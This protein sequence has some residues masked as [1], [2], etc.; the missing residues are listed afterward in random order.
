LE[1]G[2]RPVSDEYKLRIYIKIVQLFLEDEESVTAESYLNRAALI[3]NPSTSRIFS[4]QFKACQ[5]RIL[6]F[7]R[8][9]LKASP[10]YHELSYLPELQDTDQIDAL[11]SALICAVL[12]PACPQRSRLLA[13]LYKDERVRQRAEFQQGGLYQILEKMYLDRLL[14]KK[15]VEQFSENLKPHQLARHGDNTTVLDRAVTEHNLVAASKLYNNIYLNQL[16]AL[17]SI[18]EEQAELVAMKMISDGNME[19]TIDQIEKIL[20]FTNSKILPTWDAQI[21]GLCHHLDDVADRIAHFSK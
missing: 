10:K 6:D 16:G 9:F 4:L 11:R 5:A 18:S 17:L 8:D 2:H 21:S 14:N 7:K 19:G 1:S 13:T 12:A 15:E 20:F 3:I